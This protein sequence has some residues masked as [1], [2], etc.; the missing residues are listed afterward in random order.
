MIDKTLFSKGF[1]DDTQKITPLMNDDWEISQTYKN[2]SLRISSATQNISFSVLISS[3]L[4]STL[5]KKIVIDSNI[6]QGRFIFDKNREIHTEEEYFLWED[7]VENMDTSEIKKNELIIGHSYKLESGKTGIYLGFKY[8]SRITKSI[9]SLENVSKI[10]KKHLFHFDGYNS[11]VSFLNSKVISEIDKKILSSKEVNEK[12]DNFIE[13]NQSI[14]YFEDYNTISPVYKYIETKPTK[15]A[16]L[17]QKGE[18]IFVQ[19]FFSSSLGG[20]YSRENCDLDYKTTSSFINASNQQQ[21][22]NYYYNQI[23]RHFEFDKYIRIGVK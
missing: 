20:N 5:N 18:G 23:L 14:C 12:I 8:I 10:S 16:I 2:N 7:S 21:N 1:S 11:G 13:I 19:A 3:F 15:S 4:N 17:V 9:I 6:L 22:H